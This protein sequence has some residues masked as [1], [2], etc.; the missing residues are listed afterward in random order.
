MIDFIVVCVCFV[1]A[2]FLHKMISEISTLTGNLFYGWLPLFPTLLLHYIVL[3]LWSV[4]LV[5]L[6]LLPLSRW[7]KLMESL[8]FLQSFILILKNMSLSFLFGLFIMTYVYVRNQ[9]WVEKQFEQAGPLFN[10]EWALPDLMQ[11]EVDD[12]QYVL[13]HKMTLERLH[14]QE[15]SVITMM[16]LYYVFSRMHM[17]L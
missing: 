6:V 7:Q 13:P 4:S 15:M 17:F 2:T 14:F 10:F 5:T 1:V 11:E 16:S 8:P 3:F 9:N 12:D